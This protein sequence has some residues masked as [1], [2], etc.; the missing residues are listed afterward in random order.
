MSLHPNQERLLKLLAET[1]DEPLSVR[2]LM[3][4]LDV[5]SPGLV[6]HHITQ[7]EKKGY[8]KRDVNNPGNYHVLKDPEAPITF[9]NLYGLAKCGPQGTLLSGTPIDRIPMSSKLVPFNVESAFLVRARGDSME[10]EIREGDLVICKSQE[11]AESGQIVV[12]TFNESAM[13][14]KFR[15]L[16][17]KQVLLESINQKYDPIVVNDASELFIEGVFN[18]LI[19][20]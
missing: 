20:R 15:L 11:I 9:I 5:N 10:P 6:H 19:R 7:L 16:E 3:A 8:L 12:C 18:G 4:E 2:C 17:T 1:I 14:K 13:L